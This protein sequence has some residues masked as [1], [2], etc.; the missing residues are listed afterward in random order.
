MNRILESKQGNLDAYTSSDHRR[1][2]PPLI[3]SDIDG[4]ERA[5]SMLVHLRDSGVA[6]E[7]THQIVMKAYLKRG[8]L[9]WVSR[10][11]DGSEV[12]CCADQLGDMLDDLIVYQGKG[13][14]VSID[15]YNLALEAFAVCST[16]R[17]RDFGSRALMVLK[18]MEH[19]FGQDSIPIESRL[20]TLQ[21]ISWQQANR[22]NGSCALKAQELL[23]GIVERTEE[24][25]AL[26]KGYNLALYAWSKSGS[27]ESLQHAQ[28]VFENIKELNST[29]SK[30]EASSLFNAE[31]YCNMILA[32]AKLTL[33]E[34]PKQAHKLLDEMVD[35]HSKHCFPS[36]S[37]PSLLAF[38]AVI[39]AWA[40]EGNGAMAER[41]LYQLDNV[42]K[43]CQDLMSDVISYN[44]VLHAH[45]R[46]KNRDLA[47]HRMK[48]LVDRME[49]MQVDHPSVR[50][51][52]FTYVTLLKG[53]RQSRREDAALQSERLLERVEGLWAMGDSTVKP[54][55][56]YYNMV[57]NAHAKSDNQFAAKRALAILERM[58]SAIDSNCFPDV[59]SYT[60]VI[61]C[62][63]KSVEA[64]A[65][66]KAES[67]LNEAQEMYQETSDERLKPNLR[68][69]TMAILTLAR[70]H[71]SPVRARALLEQLKDEYEAS[72]DSNLLPSE[73]P[74]NYVLNCAANC[75]DDALKG[76]AFK[77]ATRTYQELRKS[78]NLSPDSYTYGFWLKCCNNLLPASDTREQCAQYSF[79]ECVQQGLVT[80]E[81]LTRLHQGLPPAV[82]K[83]IVG[84]DAC[85]S[86]ER[87][88]RA[89]S[90]NDLPVEWTRN[91]RRPRLSPA[92]V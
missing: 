85:E 2:K 59:I 52:A 84:S 77:I 75:M 26:M 50:P 1:S 62:L 46:T 87:N 79:Q 30:G 18:E 61:E 3:A 20:F 17:G 68:T 37:E 6:T 67:L 53:F 21:A 5:M 16:P 91:T 72:K 40:R 60:S 76:E 33:P 48:L 14:Q 8:R 58:K 34:A 28:S 73:Y 88:R 65:A 35:L 15:T 54:D 13:A 83:E 43:D 12:M 42:A 19:I 86:A 74:Y 38:N 51:N 32:W 49:D 78:P 92:V 66:E 36:N 89:V 45:L 27:P 57:I 10:G 22:Q 47:L 70:C 90:V 39:A 4:A 31:T 25:V 82:V 63:S 44:S 64:D 23:D 56:R 80:K 41:V 71:G 9:R 81:V 7:E 29:L 24:P 11:R 69:Y 55:N